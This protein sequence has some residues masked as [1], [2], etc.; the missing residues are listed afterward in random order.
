MSCDKLID[1]F[2]GGGK[3]GNIIKKGSE[4]VALVNNL[5]SCTEIE[6][7][8]LV[9]TLV[10]KAETEGITICRIIHGRIALC[11]KK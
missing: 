6:M 8:I 4:V 9:K 3:F 1:E 2:W 5:G 7:M 10:K 11:E